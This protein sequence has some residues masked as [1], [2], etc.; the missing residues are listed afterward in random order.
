MDSPCCC[1]VSVGKCFDADMA[2][3]SQVL[4]KKILPDL[5]QSTGPIQS[6]HDGST[7]GL[8]SRIRSL[9]SSSVEHLT[10]CGGQPALLLTH[11]DG[12]S[13]TVYLQGAHVTSYRGRDHVERLFTSSQSF[14]APGKA[15]RGGIPLCFPQFSNRGTLPP[16]G[17]F[18]TALWQLVPSHSSDSSATSVSLRL[19]SSE[20][21]MK[22]WPHE[23]EAFCHVTLSSGGLSVSVSIQNKS[24]SAMSLTG[25]LHS[26]FRVGAIERTL[27]HLKASDYEDNLAAGACAPSSSPVTFASEVDRVY[28]NA[29]SP[30]VFL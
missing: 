11:P 22:V 30:C 20:A 7:M 10:G 27:V 8:L 18:R 14:F 26:Y 24:S 25:A 23:F 6:M 13:C 9:R 29:S 16:H 5:L 12:S 1:T 3:P 2:A 21:T 28:G 19:E 15:I 4:A 17:F